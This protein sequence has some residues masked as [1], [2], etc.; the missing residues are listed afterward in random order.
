MNKGRFPANLILSHSADCTDSK[1]G[2]GCVV[3]LLDADSGSLPAHQNNVQ[4]H[5][6][7]KS[8]VF[9]NVDDG[10]YGKLT[11]DNSYNDSGGASRFYPNLPADAARFKYSPKAPQKERGDYKHPTVKPL[12]VIS[13]LCELIRMPEHNLV[14]DPFAGTG[15]TAMAA[16]N[17][18]MDYVMIEQ[19]EEYF[20]AIKHRIATYTCKPYEAP[21]LSSKLPKPRQLRLW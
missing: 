5:S 8:G 21:K 1:C 3:H 15:T 4:T 2:A 11:H 9:G 12:A 14:L 7:Y 10:Y 17:K 6:R 18:G 20:E 16:I 19:D 13:W